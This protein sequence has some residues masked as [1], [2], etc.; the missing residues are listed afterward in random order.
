MVKKLA[1][2]KKQRKKFEHEDVRSSFI[3]FR[4][5]LNANNF[6]TDSIAWFV[7]SVE[8]YINAPHALDQFMG[9]ALGTRKRP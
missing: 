6:E 9:I 3:S 4:S 1:N 2:A 8:K 5:I 7:N